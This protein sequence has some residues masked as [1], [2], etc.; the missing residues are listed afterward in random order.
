[1]TQRNFP[2]R[3]MLARELPPVDP[4]ML[5]RS[6]RTFQP[7]VQD[8]S[9][10]IS[11]LSERSFA[12]PLMAAAQAGHQQEVDRMIRTVATNSRIQTKYT[13]SGI[14]LTIEPSDAASTCCN[15]TMTLKWGL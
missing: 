6:A 14:V 9:K 3:P 10:L 15:L 7:M 5:E 8:A 1:M 12:T 11:R 13:P 4:A 2:R